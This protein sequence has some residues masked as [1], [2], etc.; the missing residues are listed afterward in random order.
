[1]EKLEWRSQHR[2]ASALGIEQKK[3]LSI[4]RKTKKKVVNEFVDY[5]TQDKSNKQCKKLA[6]VD[7]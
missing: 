1:M 5:I 2:A 7:D 4:P 6:H 3:S